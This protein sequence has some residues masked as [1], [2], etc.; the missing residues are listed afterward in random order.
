[1]DAAIEV[2]LAADVVVKIFAR[3][4]VEPIVLVKCRDRSW[5]AVWRDQINGVPWAR[6]QR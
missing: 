2:Q 4:V 6:E 1:M 3:V 5:A